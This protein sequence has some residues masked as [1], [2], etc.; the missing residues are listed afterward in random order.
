MG[1]RG[2]RGLQAGHPG[3][4]EVPTPP[5]QASG[6]PPHRLVSFLPE[7]LL[8]GP[9]H[10]IRFLLTSAHCLPTAGHRPQVLLGATAEAPSPHPYPSCTPATWEFAGL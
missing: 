7:C 2:A 6:Q 5:K 4:E 9:P 10:C 1:V 3:L 8:G